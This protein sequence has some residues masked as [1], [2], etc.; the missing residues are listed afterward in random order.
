MKGTIGTLAYALILGTVCALLLAAVGEF[1]EPYRKANAEAERKRS[2]VEVLG[3][4]TPGASAQ[5]VLEAYEVNVYA[6][7][8]EVWGDLVAHV[9]RPGG[10]QSEV[11][12][13]AIEFKGAG[14]WGPIKG[15]LAM[16]GDMKQIRGIAFYEQNETPGLGGVIADAHAG[17]HGSDWR[18]CP[19]WFRHQFEGKSIQS[20]TGERGI[21]IKKGGADGPNEFDAITAATM[22]S[23]KVEAIL[24][25]T[26]DR[27]PD[28]YH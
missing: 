2:I 16:E 14:V 13:V 26:I 17:K 19:A 6:G 12:A 27:I 9:Y 1:T 11:E 25:A 22:T 28:E 23:S 8:K 7:E 20:E 15:L 5:E 4:L 18:S 21:R 24:N 10:P 3:V